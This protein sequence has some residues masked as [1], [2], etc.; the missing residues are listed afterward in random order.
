MP[1]GLRTIH[2]P[3][4]SPVVY[5][6]YQIAAGSREEQENEEGLAHF[7]EHM[8]FKGTE[9][10]SAW[11]ILNCLEAVGGSLNAYTTKECTARRGTAHRHSVPLRISA[12]RD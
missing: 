2:M 6:G 3:S 12:K 11:N 8:T 4:D 7:C 10:R 9:R 1:C 5:L